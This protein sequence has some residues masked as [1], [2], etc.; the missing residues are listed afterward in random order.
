M[1]IKIDPEIKSLIP[2]LSND[3]LDSLHSAITLDGCRDPLVVWGSE[4]ILLD[5]HNRY[6]YCTKNNIPFKVETLECRSRHEARCWVIHNQLARRNLDASQK[7]AIAVEL[8]APLKAEAEERR[9][10]DRKSKEYQT[11]KSSGLVDTG[12][13]TEKAGKIVGV[14]AKYVAT[15]AEIKEKDPALFDQVRSGEIK[16]AEARR[17]VKR[18]TV[19]DA[20]ATD[21]NH[22]EGAI[23]NLSALI[24]AGIK[25]GCIY[26]DPP[27]RYSN[28]GTRAATNDHYCT[29]TVDEIC[30]LPIKDLCLEKAHLHMWVTNAFL[31]DAPRIFEAWGFEFKSS[32]VW[33]KSQMG[34]GNY[35]RNSHEIML[36]AV[37]G[38]QTAVSKSEMSWH[39]AKRGKHS[40]KPDFVR[41]SV[42]RL[43]PGPYLELFGRRVVEG[44]TVFGNEVEGGLV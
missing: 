43:S 25:F 33:V 35:W 3:E 9:G 32:F 5:G 42:R 27:W 6:E 20:C 2:P 11:G 44:W 23:T 40:A 21:R 31:F 26:A 24:D 19:V 13:A 37:K 4:G 8:L 34:I 36:T 12:E 39:E 38:G 14:N 41:D 30:A 1:E 17:L 28:Q 7:A 10:G 29:M 16:L 18:S 22:C 15:A